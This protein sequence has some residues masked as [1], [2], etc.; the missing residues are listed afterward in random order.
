MI[1]QPLKNY[2]L[3]GI[4]P[5]FDCGN[6]ARALEAMQQAE[7]VVA[8]TPYMTDRMR[9]YADV[10]LPINCFSETSGT[11]VNCEGRWQSFTAASRGP[12]GSRPGWKVL[13][14]LG[15]LLELDGFDQT[16]SEQVRDALAQ[17]LGD[18]S[19][20]NSQC[21]D[22]VGSKQTDAVIQRIAYLPIYAVDSIVR[23]AGALQNTPDANVCAVCLNPADANTAG[24]NTGDKAA[25]SQDSHTVELDA[26]VADAVA[27]GAA[28]LSMAIEET[29]DLGAANGSLQIKKA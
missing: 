7:F 12:A 28:L 19:V 3:M 23:R 8:L 29:L 14:V 26:I 17:Q 13:R 2:L 25:V 6:G 24:L 4:E 15:N 22:H 9:D 20:D 5:E 11:Y 18:V 1:D 27:P 10:L 21:G 16:S